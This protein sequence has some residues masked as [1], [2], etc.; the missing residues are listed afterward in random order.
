[1][2][3]LA[4]ASSVFAPPQTM[5]GWMQPFVDVNP[6]TAATDALRG[7]L[8]GGPVLNPA[9][10]PPAWT[11]ALTVVFAPLAIRRYRWLA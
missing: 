8:L 9:I 4:F 7:L 5:P 6:I 2:Y 10:Q 1:M 3:P 11:A